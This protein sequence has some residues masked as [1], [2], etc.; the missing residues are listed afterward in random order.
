MAREE[1]W[2]GFWK[3]NISGDWVTEVRDICG[4]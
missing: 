4:E 3:S 2:E 1:S